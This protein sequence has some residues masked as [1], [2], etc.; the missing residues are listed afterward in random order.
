MTSGIRG[1]ETQPRKAR[2]VSQDV[3]RNGPRIRPYTVPDWTVPV[4]PRAPI[5]QISFRVL[6]TFEN[7]FYRQFI[8]EY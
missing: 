4:H 1:P 6:G 8:R 5:E 2:V 7:N 3:P